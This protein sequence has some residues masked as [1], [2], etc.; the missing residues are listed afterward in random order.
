MLLAHENQYSKVNKTVFHF[1]ILNNG[2]S[3]RFSPPSP[4]IDTNQVQPIQNAAM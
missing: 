1:F 2:S 3:G 4:K